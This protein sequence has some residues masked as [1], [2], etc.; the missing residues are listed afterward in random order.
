M[1][2]KKFKVTYNVDMVFCIDATGSM[3]SVIDMV[4]DNAIHLYEDVMESMAL[5]GKTIDSLRVKLIAFRDYLAD[6]GNAMLASEFF[7]LPKETREFEECVKSIE[8]FGGGDDP[9]DGLEALGY[10][11]K[12]RWNNEGMKKRQVIV[13]WTD[14]PTHN[15][16]EGS[17]APN[18]PT[19][20]AKD[21]SE[22]TSWWGDTENE[23]F[24]NQSAKR[25]LLFAPDATHW[26]TISDTWDNVI[27]FPSVAG[28]GLGEFDYQ[29]II[30]AISNTI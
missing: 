17:K 25:L 16:G 11:I 12:S 18:Y 8:A 6:E 3:G 10:A 2:I 1:N 5:K 30:D 9:E 28:A 22:L 15:L 24:I 4:K 7:S 19:K 26:N 23:G 14:A 20:M 13:V 27:H 29:Q 21:F